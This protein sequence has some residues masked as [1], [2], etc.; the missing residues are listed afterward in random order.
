ML[1]VLVPAL[2]L[3]FR[4]V[5]PERL[6]I[7][8]V[9]ALATHTAWQWMFERWDALAKF[10]YPRLDAAFAGERRCAARWRCSSSRAAVWLVKGLVDRWLR[11]A[12]PAGAELAARVPAEPS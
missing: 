12:K 5:V 8:I 1:L 3:L 7:I 10:P 4:F 9:S 2:G 11:A 6:G